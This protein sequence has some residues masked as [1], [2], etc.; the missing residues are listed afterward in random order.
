MRVILN[1]CLLSQRVRL[2]GE[3]SSSTFRWTKVKRL[4]SGTRLSLLPPSR[5]RKELRMPVLTKTLNLPRL[6]PRVIMWRLLSDVG[7]RQPSSQTAAV[8]KAFRP[9]LHRQRHTGI[10]EHFHVYRS[11]DDVQRVHPECSGCPG[12]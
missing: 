4:L 1:Y 10:I 7:T 6:W 3:F 5:T 9:Y 12:R 11:A 8:D 2:C